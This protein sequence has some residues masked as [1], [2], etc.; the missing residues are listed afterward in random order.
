MNARQEEEKG[1][2]IQRDQT[3]D[4]ISENSGWRQTMVVC[5]SDLARKEAMT[6]TWVGNGKQAEFL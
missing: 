2:Q 6:V 5:S 4:S 3:E 1:A